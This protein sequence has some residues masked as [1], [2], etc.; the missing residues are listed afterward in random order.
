MRERKTYIRSLSFLNSIRRSSSSSS[1][2][3]I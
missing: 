2:K 1:S 3:Q